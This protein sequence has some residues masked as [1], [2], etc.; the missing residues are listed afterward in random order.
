MLIGYNS[1]TIYQIYIKNQRKVIKVKDF[2]IFEDYKT[3]RST[4]FSDNNNK[5]TFHGF[6]FEDNNKRS[7]ELISTYVE[8][9]KVTNIKENQISNTNTCKG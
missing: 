3:K 8:G 7:E 4:K 2:C 1:H 6:F 9:Q 5:P